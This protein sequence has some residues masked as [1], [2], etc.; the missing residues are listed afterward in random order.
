MFDGGTFR[1]YRG[2]RLIEQW[3]GQPD[4]WH[5]ELHLFA[6][7]EGFFWGRRQDDWWMREGVVIDDAK[8]TIRLAST[9]GDGQASLVVDLTSRMAVEYR[10][11]TGTLTVVEAVVGPPD[12]SFAEPRRTC[13]DEEFLAQMRP[14]S[15][16]PGAVRW[17]G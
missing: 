8:A 13:T 3:Q 4:Y 9:Q 1:S 2:A 10:R 16:E 17:A 12:L 11:P 5:P 6:P 7:I 15:R 14:R